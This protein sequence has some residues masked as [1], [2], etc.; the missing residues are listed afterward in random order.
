M[1]TENTAH[2]ESPPDE[3]KQTRM[4]S[5]PAETKST[6]HPNGFEFANDEITGA[7]GQTDVPPRAP[8]QLPQTP[9]GAKYSWPENGFVFS[10]DGNLLSIHNGVCPIAVMYPGFQWRWPVCRPGSRL[11]QRRKIRPVSPLY[12]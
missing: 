1:A 6:P 4:H 3:A 5:Q 7:A 2:R 11:K 8:T 9:A 12:N 10:N